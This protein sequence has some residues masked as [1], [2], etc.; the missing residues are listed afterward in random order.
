MIKIENDQ[1]L[2]TFDEETGAMTRLYDKTRKLDYIVA[3][4]SDPFRLELTDL[5]TSEYDLFTWKK[6]DSPEGDAKLD[7]TWMLGNI[8][9]EASVEL[10]IQSDELIFNCHLENNSKQ[11]IIGLEY[12]IIP[13]MDQITKDGEQDYFIHSFATGVK[14][15]NPLKNFDEKSNGFRHMPYPE[16]FSGATMQFQSFYGD[17]T[18]GLYFA[19]YDSD[20]YSKW[21]NFYK[22]DHQLLEASF[23]HG[24]EDVGEFKGIEVTYPTVV[25]MLAGEG[26][27]EAAD[28]YKEWATDQYWCQ[29][30][31]MTDLTDNDKATWLLED[32]GVSTFGIN[33]G[34]DRSKWI[35]K[36]HEHIDEKIFHILGP[37]WPQTTQNFGGRVPG[38]MDDWF[39]TRFN[40]E[41]LATIEAVGDKYAPFEFDYLFNVNGAD[42]EAGK[43][44]LQDIPER[45]I[46]SLDMYHFPLLCPAAPYTKKFHVDRDRELQAEMRVDSIYYDISANNILKMCMDE[47]HNH[48]KGAGREITMAHR[49]NYINSKEAMIEETNGQYV[50]MGTEM[51]NE[52]FLDLLDYYQARAGARPA[53]PLEAYNIQSLIKQGQAE[54]IPLFTYV[55]HEYGAVRLDGWGKLVEEIGSLFYFT[56]AR[57]YLWGGLYELNYEYSPMES[58]D[59]EENLASEHYAKFEE[60]GYSF[61]PERADYLSQFSKLRTGQGN[62]Y[63]AYGKM[64]KPLSFQQEKVNLNWFHYNCSMNFS[65][66]NDSGEIAED[67]I[68]HSA[69]EYSGNRGYFF[70]NVADTEQSV[71]LKVSELNL[72]ENT[73]GLKCYS[74]EA[75]REISI[76]ADQDTIEL[77]I[78]KREVYMIEI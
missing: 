75:V 67:A 24:C 30:G 68:V 20:S 50:P 19:A 26:W 38:G 73:R 7:F 48:P 44:A 40:P 51:I 8:K 3:H 31:Q 52:V 13:N 49:E 65:E 64:L 9:I 41:I 4:Q 11:S 61:S 54:M 56:V 74:G 72:P 37:D 21:L 78:P 58:I 28:I 12:P 77:S 14:V 43:K 18:G 32:V 39:P 42:G 47:S 1:L 57:T 46:K 34:H 10:A 45:Y 5:T 17:E 6:V 29:K 62:K 71:Q 35:N 16:S 60:R 59:G 36:Y 2:G 33:A 70:A 53:A 15:K 69:W 76:A 55:Y 27:Y 22:N 63:L 66:Y 25:K 23:I